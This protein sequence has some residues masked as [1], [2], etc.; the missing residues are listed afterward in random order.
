MYIDEHDTPITMSEVETDIH[1]LKPGKAAGDDDIR[2][3]FVLYGRASLKS[4]IRVLFNKLYNVRFYPE[5]LST[6]VIR[7][8]TNSLQTTEASRFYIIYI[9][10]KQCFTIF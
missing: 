3:E 8:A 7:K 2:S 6:G 5:I 10:L 1:H 4:S 9:Y